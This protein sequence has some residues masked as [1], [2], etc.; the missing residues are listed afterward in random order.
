[1]VI[2][3]LKKR[4][5]ITDHPKRFDLHPIQIA[6][7]KKGFISKA[8]FV[9]KDATVPLKI[10]MDKEKQKLYEVIGYQKVGIDFLKKA[11]HE[12]RSR[13]AA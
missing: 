5:N 9:F 2:E 3:V 1:V 7:W 12:I 13:R 6:N 11:C 10:S 8:A 4:E